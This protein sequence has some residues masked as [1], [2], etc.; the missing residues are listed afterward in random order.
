MKLTNRHCFVVNKNSVLDTGVSS[1]TWVGLPSM[2]WSSFS[3]YILTSHLHISC[4]LKLKKWP[5]QLESTYG[6]LIKSVMQVLM[7]QNSYAMTERHVFIIETLLTASNFYSNDLHW[8]SIWYIHRFRII[9]NWVKVYTLKFIHA[10]GGGMSRY[11]LL[12]CWCVAIIQC[13]S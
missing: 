12:F 2:S 13:S 6:N 7:I 10:M 8:Q 5:R 3:G 11:E 9:M 4:T 1:T